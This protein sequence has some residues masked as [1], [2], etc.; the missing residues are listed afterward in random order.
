MDEISEFGWLGAGFSAFFQAPID[1][2]YLPPLDDPLA[3]SEWLDGFAMAHAERP[4]EEAM[5]SILYGNGMG[6]E[7]ME[8]ALRRQ[9]LDYPELTSTLLGLSIGHA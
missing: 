8:D 5:E 7:S 1:P 6:G 2:D 9:L 4:D 3:Q